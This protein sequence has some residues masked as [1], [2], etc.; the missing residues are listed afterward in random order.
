MRKRSTPGPSSAG[1]RVTV[2]STA[3]E[4]TTIAPIAIE[5]TAFTSITNRPAS[6]TATVVPL[7][8]TAVPELASARRRA[9]SDG[10]PAFS[11]RR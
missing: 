6:D 7:K 2:A 3:I 5:R 9:S 11:S 4:T 10:A 1:R 8:T